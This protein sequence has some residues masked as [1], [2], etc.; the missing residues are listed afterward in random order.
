MAPS[1][2]DQYTREHPAYR[3]GYAAG[4]DLGLRQALD[5]LTAE[6]IRL[7]ALADVLA[8][9]ATGTTAARITYADGRLAAVAAVIAG[10]FRR[11][12]RHQQ[13]C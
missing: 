8:G 9:S 11:A 13:T 7:D 2:Y 3:A 6:R 4:V 12:A 5:A 1:L 10:I